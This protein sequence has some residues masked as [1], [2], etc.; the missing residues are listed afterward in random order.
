[1]YSRETERKNKQVVNVKDSQETPGSF[2]PEDKNTMEWLWEVMYLNDEEIDHEFNEVE[3]KKG[4]PKRRAGLNTR[5]LHKCITCSKVFPSKAH[6]KEHEVSHSN[7]QPY[8]CLMCDRGFKRKNAL[9]KHM[10]IFHPDE[11]NNVYCSCGKVYAS[12]ELLEKHRECSGNHRLFVCPECGAFYR[13]ESSLKSHMM[14][15]NESKGSASSSS[16]PFTCHTCSEKLSSQASL[17][18]HIINSHSTGDFQC[19]HCDKICKTRQLL[20]QH[21]LRKHKTGNKEFPCSVCNKVFHISKDLRRHMQSHNPE[22]LLQCP[23]CHAKFKTYST[24]Q[25]HMKIHSQ[26][27]PYDCVICLLPCATIENLKSHLFSHH[28]IEAGDDFAQNWNRRC[29]LCGQIFLRRSSLALHIKTHIGSED[30]QLFFVENIDSDTVIGSN[31][32]K[33]EQYQMP[34]LKM[35]ARIDEFNDIHNNVTENDCALQVQIEEREK[36]NK[37]NAIEVKVSHEKQI[38]N[39][40]EMYTNVGILASC[41]SDGDKRDVKILSKDVMAKQFIPMEAG[42]FVPEPVIATRTIEETQIIGFKSH[43][44][45]KDK[46]HNINGISHTMKS[47]TSNEGEETKYICGECT[48]VFTD[49]ND[50]RTHLST[51]YQQDNSDEYVVVFEVDENVQK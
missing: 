18:N 9:S 28:N 8:R 21:C 6:L 30:I 20:S 17:S 45:V 14:L 35:Y 29:P 12:Q 11:S 41:L 38:E 32:M 48:L 33:N 37:R 24:L 27:K 26:G 49:V 25:S 3:E 51:C 40:K 5:R 47:C 19:H 43:S 23:A 31:S 10:R 46:T 36:K 7:K 13:T 15:H 16:W 22:G 50:L 39:V 42:K 44:V 4:L 2:K 34:H 1:M